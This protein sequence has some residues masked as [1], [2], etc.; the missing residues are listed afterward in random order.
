MR[1]GLTEGEFGHVS[2]RNRARFLYLLNTSSTQHSSGE[3]LACDDYCHSI[4]WE[5]RLATA[6]SF[7]RDAIVTIKEPVLPFH[8]KLSFQ[9]A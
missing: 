2:R 1:E 8:V 4:F 3:V 9:E 6:L 7:S 5:Q